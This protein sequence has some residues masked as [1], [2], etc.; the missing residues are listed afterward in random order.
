[1]RL[2]TTISFALII[3]ATAAISAQTC[4]IPARDCVGSADY[5]TALVPFEPVSGLGYDNYPINGE[6]AKNQYRSYARRD[7]TMLVKHAAAVVA[8]TAKGWSPGNGLAIGLG[9]MSEKTGAIPGTSDNDPGHPKGTHINGRDMDIAYYQLTGTNNQLRAV[10][11]HI[12]KNKNVKHCTGVPDNL[13]VRR[14]ALFIGTLLTSDRMR[15]VGVD[16]KIEPLVIPEMLKL[17]EQGILPKIACQRQIKVLS[18]TTNTGKGWYLNHH[19]HLHISLKKVGGKPAPTD[20]I[21][22]GNAA[23]SSEIER[24]SREGLL[25]HALIVNPDKDQ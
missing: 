14:T 20:V 16:G 6:T 18:E 24:L 21:A 10:C 9:D 25:G 19:H 4:V 8:C 22:P 7:L 12:A 13:D 2:A 5:C 15:V 17:C 23:V 11:P 1:M 3:G